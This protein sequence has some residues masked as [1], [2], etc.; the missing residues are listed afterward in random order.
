[1]HIRCKFRVVSI[2]R[3]LIHTYDQET[4]T[5]GTGEARTIKFEVSHDPAFHACTPSGVI[6][7]SMVKEEHSRHFKLGAEYFSD[8]TPVAE[9]TETPEV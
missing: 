2:L 3:H 4:K 8:F 1:M 6:E 7:L 5:S 9:Q